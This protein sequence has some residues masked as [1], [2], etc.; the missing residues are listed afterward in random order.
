MKL[1]YLS[2]NPNRVDYDQHFGFVIRAESEADARLLAS[3]E[4][5]REFEQECWL[6]KNQTSIEELL[7]DG[8]QEIIVSDF[9]AG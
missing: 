5:G 6:D 7:A 9:N 1:Y 8:K 3:K 4:C 2:R